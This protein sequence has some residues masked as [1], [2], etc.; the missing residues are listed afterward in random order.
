V[1]KAL[2]LLAEHHRSRGSRHNSERSLFPKQ[3]T[4]LASESDG[5]GFHLIVDLLG[6]AQGGLHVVAD[7]FGSD[8]RFEL[9][10]VNQVRWL[11]ARAAE[12]QGSIARVQLA[13]YFF[14][15]E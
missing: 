1:V 8:Y 6:A 4:T 3:R 12:D 15:G 5:G 7:I 14:D 13:G 2:E 11:L 9:S 10:L